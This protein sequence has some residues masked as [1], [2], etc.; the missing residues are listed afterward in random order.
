MEVTHRPAR[1]RRGWPCKPRGEQYVVTLSVDEYEDL[2][3]LV[4]EGRSL[5]AKLMMREAVFA[6]D[7]AEAASHFER[8]QPSE[9]RPSPHCRE[10]TCTIGIYC[11][12]SCKPCYDAVVAGHP[13]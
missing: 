1:M 7:F 8:S 3:T 6:E 10:D 4:K 9:A 5:T 2:T 12:C 11:E 13:R